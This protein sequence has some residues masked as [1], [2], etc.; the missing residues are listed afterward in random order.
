MSTTQWL[1]CGAD[2]QGATRLSHYS[3][4]APAVLERK[5]ARVARRYV[6]AKAASLLCNL[7]GTAGTGRIH[8]VVFLFLPSQVLSW[9]LLTLLLLLP[10]P[11]EDFSTSSSALI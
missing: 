7:E 8:D 9:I 6:T 1:V 2:M 5:I 4:P 10:E 3:A 11:A